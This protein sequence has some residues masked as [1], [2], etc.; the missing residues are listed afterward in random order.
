MQNRNKLLACLYLAGSD[1]NRYKPVVDDL[2]NEF[3]MGKISYPE[4]VPSMAQL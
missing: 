4:D 2:G 3:R 1:Q